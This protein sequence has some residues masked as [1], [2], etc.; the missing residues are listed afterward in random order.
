[1]LVISLLRC[2]EC[3]R[4]EHRRRIIMTAAHF[5]ASQTVMK[6]S[7]LVLV[8]AVV[9]AVVEVEVSLRLTDRCEGSAR[10]Q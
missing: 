1:M 5:P 7:V 8:V 10:R 6:V 9:E 4:S 2:P 3:T